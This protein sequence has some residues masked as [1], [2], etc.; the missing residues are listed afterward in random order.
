[1]EKRCPAEGAVDQGKGNYRQEQAESQVAF[2]PYV[3]QRR[4]QFLLRRSKP[5]ASV[6]QTTGDP[7]IARVTAFPVVHCAFAIA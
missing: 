1:M 4:S 2:V 5:C 6:V 3:P 7:Q